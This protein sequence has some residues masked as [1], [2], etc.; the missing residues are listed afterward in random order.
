MR[1]QNRSGSTAGNIIKR[2]FLSASYTNHLSIIA[3]F[4]GED[5]QLTIFVQEGNSEL[6]I[7]IFLIAQNVVA[8]AVGECFDGHRES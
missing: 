5:C 4:E 7:A 6:N 2:R 8:I 3:G 1:H